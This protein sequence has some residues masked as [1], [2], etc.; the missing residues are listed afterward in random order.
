M[1]MADVIAVMNRGRIEQAGSAKELYDYPST[2]F[3]ANFLGQSNLVKATVGAADGEYKVVTTHDGLRFKVLERRI[4]T[5]TGEFAVGVRPEKVFIHP[6]G[7]PDPVDSRSN[8]IRARV[9]TSAFLGVSLEYHVV[10]QG[11]DELI[12]TIQNNAR[13]QAETIADGSEVELSW[14]PDHTFVVTV[15][16]D[17]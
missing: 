11:G 8:R 16:A 12:V 17:A 5:G 14:E 7:T 15:G 13:E 6:V 10:T 2:A 9:V 3:V 4:A 1:T